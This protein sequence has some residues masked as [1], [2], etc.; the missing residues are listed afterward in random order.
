ML[1]VRTQAGLSRAISRGKQRLTS[2]SK[3]QAEEVLLKLNKGAMVAALARMHGTS[4]KTII[5]I[6]ES[7]TVADGTTAL[8]MLKVATNR[9]IAATSSDQQGVVRLAA[10]S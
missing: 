1:I 10:S 2:L 6:R 4:H 5:R 8:A 3:P 9:K 7:Q